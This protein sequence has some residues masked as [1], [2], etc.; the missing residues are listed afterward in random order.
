MTGGNVTTVNGSGL[1][2]RPIEPTEPLW[3]P[4]D[5]HYRCEMWTPTRQSSF[6]FQRVPTR[7]RWPRR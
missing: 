7:S 3:I 6:D 4:Q 2:G 1:D 5:V